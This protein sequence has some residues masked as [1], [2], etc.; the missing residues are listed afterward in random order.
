MHQKFNRVHHRKIVRKVIT[1]LRTFSHVPRYYA[2]S[3]LGGYL[4]VE[5]FSL[6]GAVNFIVEMPQ[7]VMLMDPVT[8]EALDLVPACASKDKLSLF[9]HLDE[10]ETPGGSRRLLNM[11]LQ[12]FKGMLE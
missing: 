2:I 11:I 1:V 9:H 3:A 6:A 4:S 10:T 8:V 5:S 7:G 12:P